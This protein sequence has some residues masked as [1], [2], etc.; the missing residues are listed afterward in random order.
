MTISPSLANA[1]ATVLTAMVTLIMGYITNYIR[2]KTKSVK[3]NNQSVY[4]YSF[5]DIVKVAI[6]YAEQAYGTFS[7]KAKFDVAFNYLSNEMKNMGLTV[8]ASQIQALIESTLLQLKLD[9][10]S[11]TTNGDPKPVTTSINK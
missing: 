9:Y 3:K 11:W 10:P 1:L 7:G 8:S 2:H 5:Q 4:T 6:M